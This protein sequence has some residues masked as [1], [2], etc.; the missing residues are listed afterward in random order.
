M[1]QEFEKAMKKNVLRIGVSPTTVGTAMATEIE[2][3]VARAYLMARRQLPKNAV[4]KLW[5]SCN[6]LYYTQDDTNEREMNKKQRR[7]TLIR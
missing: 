3:F 6:F 5:A 4:F 1:K 2:A 7:T